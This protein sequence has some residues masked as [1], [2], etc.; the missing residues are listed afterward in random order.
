VIQRLAVAQHHAI[1]TPRE[2]HA[3]SLDLVVQS[4]QISLRSI[5]NQ[6]HNLGMERTR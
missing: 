5:D 1:T 3:R 2:S 4:Q 6:A